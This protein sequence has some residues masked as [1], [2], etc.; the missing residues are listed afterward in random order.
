VEARKLSLAAFLVCQG[1]LACASLALAGGFR[2]ALSV[3]LN[4]FGHATEG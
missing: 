1:A 3:F 4:S 2:P